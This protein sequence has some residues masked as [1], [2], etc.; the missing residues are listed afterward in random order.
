MGTEV[1]SLVTEADS[2]VTIEA[3][4]DITIEAVSDITIEAS[5]DIVTMAAA[6]IITKADSGT[7]VATFYLDHCSIRIFTEDIAACLLSLKTFHF[8]NTTDFV[9]K[10]PKNQ[11]HVASAF[12]FG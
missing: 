9:F 10:C 6:Y 3:T 11:D 4:S 8:A 7:I 2:D 1:L 12:Y 5:S